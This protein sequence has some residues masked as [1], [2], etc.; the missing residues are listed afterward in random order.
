MQPSGRGD[1][2]RFGLSGA[3]AVERFEPRHSLAHRPGQPAP[4][5]IHKLRAQVR[6]RTGCALQQAVGSLVGVWGRVLVEALDG[7]PSRIG[8]R[9]ARQGLPE[10]EFGFIA[11]QAPVN[12]AKHHAVGAVFEDDPLGEQ[13]LFD[14]GE[15]GGPNQRFAGAGSHVAAERGN[16]QR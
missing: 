3:D 5:G 13:R 12:A 11:D 6:E 2:L 8:A 4:E 16:A 14:R 7:D 9:R 1:P 10:G 15:F